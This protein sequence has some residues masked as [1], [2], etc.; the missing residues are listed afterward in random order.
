MI[1]IAP[2]Y[3]DNLVFRQR[4]GSLAILALVNTRKWRDSSQL[5]EDEIIEFLTKTER[6]KCTNTQKILLDGRHLR[7]CTS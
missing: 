5:P 3:T 2:I 1:D 4:R 7:M 6:N